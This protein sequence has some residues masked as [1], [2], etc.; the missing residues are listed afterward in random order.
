MAASA[1]FHA[2]TDGEEVLTLAFAA[3][4]WTKITQVAWKQ[5]SVYHSFSF[6]AFRCPLKAM[7][8]HTGREFPCHTQIELIVY[9]K[10][11]TLWFFFKTSLWKEINKQIQTLTLS[12]P[13][14]QPYT[15]KRKQKD[16]SFVQLTK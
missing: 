11:K 7:T 9:N 1:L 4:F 8:A 16:S 13:F 14:H 15:K 12:S 6:A 10:F 5:G 2:V 3:F